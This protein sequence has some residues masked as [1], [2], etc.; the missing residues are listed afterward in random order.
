VNRLCA[1]PHASGQDFRST[2]VLAQ[3]DDIAPIPGTKHR[4]YLH[5]NVGALDVALTSE[6][7]ARIEDVAPKS[8]FAGARY[9][10]WAMAMV[11][12]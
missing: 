6:D 8:A 12:R 9:P 7:V 5:E 11:N 4:E 2:W 10:E 3:G 1:K